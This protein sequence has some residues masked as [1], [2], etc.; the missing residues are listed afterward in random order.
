[1]SKINWILINSFDELSNFNN[2]YV[3][4]FKHSPR[5][6]VSRITLSRFELNYNN[7]IN[8]PI[9]VYID[10]LNSRDL[11]KE[12]AK[13]YSVYHE[14]PQIILLKNNNVLFHASHSEISFSRLKNYTN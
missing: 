11:S 5:C 14:S 9:F 10:V 2:N 4:L 1:M 7:K 8:I 3:L 6:I 12:I 13:N